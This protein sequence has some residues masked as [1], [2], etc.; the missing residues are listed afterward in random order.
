M[1]RENRVLV[2][3]SDVKAVVL[4]A[5]RA[6]KEAQ[7][8]IARVEN[9]IQMV[10]FERVKREAVSKP[11]LWGGKEVEAMIKALLTSLLVS[12]YE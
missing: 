3:K 4:E 10:V 1:A 9:K 6:V 7:R 2:K 8:S 12:T 5:A 11:Q